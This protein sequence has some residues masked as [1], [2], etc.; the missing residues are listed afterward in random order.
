MSLDQNVETEKVGRGIDMQILLLLFHR[1][2][3][4]AQGAQQ[5]TKLENKGSEVIWRTR[6][7]TGTNHIH[8][9]GQRGKRVGWLLSEGGRPLELQLAL[10]GSYR[11]RI[12]DILAQ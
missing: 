12:A 4:G 6:E 1:G 7:K 11:N 5:T 2:G 8:Q 3:N 10:H 9:G